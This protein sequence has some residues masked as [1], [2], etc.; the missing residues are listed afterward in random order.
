MTEGTNTDIASTAIEARISRLGAVGSPPVI[1][2]VTEDQAEQALDLT[3]PSEIDG[4]LESFAVDPKQYRPLTRFR[5][6]RLDSGPE[7]EVNRMTRDYT[8][9]TRRGVVFRVTVELPNKLVG[10]AAFQPGSFADPALVPANGFPYISVIAVSED[11]RG[12]RKGGVRLGDLV[13]LDALHAIRCDGRFSKNRNVFVMVHP[14]NKPG[15]A[16]FARNGFHLFTA[17]E[18]GNPI[19]E[20]MLIRSGSPV[21]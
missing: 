1:G 21:P 9:G 18:P 11:Y 20:S 6:G 3:V 7:R 5:C 13:L 14:G 16:M 2:G 10:L 19:A 12:R 17:A 15:N 8:R 4:D